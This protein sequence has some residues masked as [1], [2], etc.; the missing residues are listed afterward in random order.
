MFF[1]CFHLFGY[2]SL[3]IL[4][5]ISDLSN[6]VSFRFSSPN[7][8]YFSLDVRTKVPNAKKPHPHISQRNKV[9]GFIHAVLIQPPFETLFIEASLY[10]TQ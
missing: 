9:M 4:S 10:E 5:I 6:F 3:S 8:V 7:L 1:Y 2:I